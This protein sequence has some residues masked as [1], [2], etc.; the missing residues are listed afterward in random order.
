MNIGARWIWSHNCCEKTGTRVTTAVAKR[1]SGLCDLQS[2]SHSTTGKIIQKQRKYYEKIHVQVFK[3]FWIA[4]SLEEERSTNLP[5]FTSLDFRQ[6][7]ILNSGWPM[8]IIINQSNPK[9]DGVSG[10]PFF[11]LIAEMKMLTQSGR[12]CQFLDRYFLIAP[13][14]QSNVS[15]LSPTNNSSKEGNVNSLNCGSK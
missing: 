6:S 8:C 13:I 15:S 2:R 4:V 3:T 10:Y 1:T 5:N 12:Y 7:G 11:L 9:R 14:G